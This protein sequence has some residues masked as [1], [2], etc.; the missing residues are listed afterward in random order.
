V[1]SKTTNAF[2]CFDRHVKLLTD[3]GVSWEMALNRKE[4]SKGKMD[5]FY[6]SKK[7]QKGKRLYLLAIQKESSSHLFTITRYTFYKS[8]GCGQNYQFFVY[9][10][11]LF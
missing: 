7:E 11:F 9:R 8:Y 10:Q 4:Q 6:C 2:I 3:R 1:V 5:G